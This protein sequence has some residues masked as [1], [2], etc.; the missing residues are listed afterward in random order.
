[1]N[2]KLIKK[3]NRPVPQ[4]TWREIARIMHNARVNRWEAATGL[5]TYKPYYPVAGQYY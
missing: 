5:R 2:S 1:M 3:I 4:N